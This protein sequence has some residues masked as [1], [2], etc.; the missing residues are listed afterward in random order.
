MKV[1]IVT[2]EEAEK[3]MKEE[4]KKSA[5]IRTYSDTTNN[6]LDRY[7]V[8]R[9]VPLPEKSGFMIKKDGVLQTKTVPSVFYKPLPP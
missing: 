1:S 9:R 6:A 3:D 7:S 2:D 5:P 8:D 4:E